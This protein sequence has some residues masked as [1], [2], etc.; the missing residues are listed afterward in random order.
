MVFAQSKTVKGTVVDEKGEAI[1]GASVSVKGTTTGTMTDLDGNFS[2]IVNNNDVLTISY[3]G[4]TEQSVSVAG[5]TNVRVVLAED[6]QILEEFVVVG[7]GVQKKTD[8]TGA[9]AR[10]G[11]KELT[12]MPVKDAVQAMQGKAAGVDITSNQRPGQTGEIRIRGV[13]SIGAD[14]GPLYVVDGM[15]LQSGAS[16]TGSGNNSSGIDNLNPNDIESIDIL[17]DASATA[18]YGSRG[19]NGVVLVTTKRGK[20]GALSVNYSG[21]VTLEKLYNVSENMSAAEWLEYARIAKYNIGTYGSA[22]PSYEADYALWGTLGLSWENIAKGWTNNNTVWDPSKVGS[23]D[24]EKHGKRTG[25]STEHTLS[26]SGGNEKAQGYASFGYLKQEGTQPGQDFTRYSGKVSFDASP[27]KWFKMGAS[28]NLAWSNQDYGYNFTKSETGAGDYYSALRGML[29]WT[30]PYDENGNNIKYPN[31]DM[32]IINPIDELKYTQNNRQTLNTFGNIYAQLDFGE[33]YSPLKGLK[34]RIQ[35]GP[36]FKYYTTGTFNDEDGINGS[37]NNIA[38]YNN[39]QTRAWTLDNLVYYDRNFGLDHKLGLTLMQSASKY[40]YEDATAKATDV[41][42]SEELW[43][44]LGSGGSIGTFGSGLVERQLASYMIRANYGF[45]DKYLLTASVRWDGASQLADGNKW[46]SFTSMALGWRID[47]EKFME[48]VKAVSALKLRLGVGTTG[49]AAISAYATKGGLT[50][51]YYN[52]GTTSSSSGYIPS[53]PT[54]K[55]PSKMPNPDLSWERTT[56]YNVGVDYG[57]LK[58]RINGSIDVY[59]SITNDLLLPMS[60]PSLVGYVSTYANVGKTE[61]WGIDLQINSTNI[62]TKDFTWSTTLTWSKDRN[63]IK[64]LANGRSEDIENNLFVGKEIGVYYDYVYDGIWKTSEAE[65]AAKY[66]RK[67]GQIRVKDLDGDGTID[68]NY[69]RK[70]VGSIRPDWSGGITNTFNYKNLELSFFIY[71]RW[72]FTVP[73]GALTLDGRYQMRKIDYWVA[74]TN[75]NARYYSPGS[76]GEAADTYTSSMN[77]QDGSF[78]KMRNI[79]IGY[80]FNQR[81]IK[82]LGIKNL[83]VYAQLMNPFTIYSKCDY[84]DTDLSNYDNNKT[85]VGSYTTTRALVFGLNIGF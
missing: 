5:K 43:Y 82:Q 55:T 40:H 65:E 67:P 41:A 32:N 70:V 23:Y 60:I 27:T 34:Y 22:T 7:Y 48:N 26:V 50:Q 49:N 33:M 35:F 44:N 83:K 28:I 79:N 20:A 54:V 42:T 1:I 24:W 11:E 52:W 78:I 29:A 37:G 47:Q 2:I 9:M 61:G 19:A 72:G 6:S 73:N 15:V 53:D 18:I 66:G 76:N 21:T 30:V 84:L 59:K 77:Y 74:G 69:D 45:R 68:A 36:E 63:K 17:K 4:Y 62:E 13:R 64:E 81:Q 57:F 12:A 25:V 38:S 46:A 10:V 16:G 56:Q 85:T 80:N 14:Q 58:N 71:S 3:V 31:G 8:V 51:N 39:Y 75:E